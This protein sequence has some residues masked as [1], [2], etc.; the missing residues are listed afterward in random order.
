[1]SGLARGVRARQ[2]CVSTLAHVVWRTA[3][4]A[5]GP[6]PYGFRI[7]ALIRRRTLGPTL[8]GSPT[9]HQ[10]LPPA[11]VFINLV[12]QAYPTTT[13]FRI[14]YRNTVNVKNTSVKGQAATGTPTTM[15]S[16][17]LPPSFINSPTCHKCSFFFLTQCQL[18]WRWYWLNHPVLLKKIKNIFFLKKKTKQNSTL[19][20]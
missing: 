14:I 3:T 20:L 17:F 10:R 15:A 6:H 1:M 2:A 12:K 7:E 19:S 8:L 5:A 9:L 16:S 18:V 4:W 11:L 13:G